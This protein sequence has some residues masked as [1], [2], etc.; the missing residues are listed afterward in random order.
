MIFPLI[1]V[2]PV[3]EKEPSQ[4]D[5]L[6]AKHCGESLSPRKIANNED[7][8]IEDVANAHSSSVLGIAYST[9]LDSS[10]DYQASKGMMPQ[11]SEIPHLDV[12]RNNFSNHIAQSCFD[13]IEKYGG[14]LSKGQILFHGGQWPVS[15]VNGVVGTNFET[16]RVLSTSLCPKVATV[17]ACYHEPH[18]IWVM[19]VVTDIQTKAVI[20]NDD[21]SEEMG[22]EREVAFNKGLKLKCIG[23]RKIHV[24]T[25]LSVEVS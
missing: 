20:F 12:Y 25:V 3:I 5:L 19:K 7:T 24:F 13:E 11:S 23:E 16:D 6:L 1:N 21:S 2:F 22:H 18:V 14:Y 17:H 9:A 8:L 10:S 4:R 15:N